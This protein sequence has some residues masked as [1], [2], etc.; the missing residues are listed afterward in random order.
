VAKTE[1][2]R[3]VWRMA[4]EGREVGGQHGMSETMGGG[5]REGE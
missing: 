2:Q 3:S 1:G 5:Q 4:A